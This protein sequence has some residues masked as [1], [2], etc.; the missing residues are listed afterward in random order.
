MPKRSGERPA[1]K[2]KRT[3]KTLDRE[4]VKQA[5]KECK[6]AAGLDYAYSA[7]ISDCMSCTNYA[8]S[9]KYGETSRGIWLKWYRAGMNAREWDSQETYYICHDLT[10]EQGQKVKEVLSK[11]F[12]VEWDGDNN[13]CIEISAKEAA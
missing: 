6:K 12:K 10:S 11:Y 9:K 13:S 1:A 3:M 7:G 8:I 5:I 4:T 2:E